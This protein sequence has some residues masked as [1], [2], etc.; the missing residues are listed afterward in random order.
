[1]S[2]TEGSGGEARRGFVVRLCE[3]LPGVELT[4]PFGPQPG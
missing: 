2:A 3:E 4:F 1:V